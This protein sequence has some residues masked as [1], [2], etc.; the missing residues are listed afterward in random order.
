MDLDFFAAKASPEESW[1][2]MGK[3]PSDLPRERKDSSGEW[4]DT[5]AVTKDVSGAGACGFCG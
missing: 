1:K 5:R 2:S 4:H 3:D